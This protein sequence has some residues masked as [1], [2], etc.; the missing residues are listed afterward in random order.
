MS[1]ASRTSLRRR[2]SF[3]VALTIALI[4][5]IPATALGAVSVAY[6]RNGSVTPIQ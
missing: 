1:L 2:L 4:A 6:S 3:V 5:V